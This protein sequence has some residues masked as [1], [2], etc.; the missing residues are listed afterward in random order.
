MV[1]F[2]G[3][4]AYDHAE[5]YRLMFG[6]MLESR[7]PLVFKCSAGKDRTGVAAGLI[8]SLLGVPREHITMVDSLGVIYKGRGDGMNPYKEAFARSTELRTL[9]DAMRGCD[10]FLGCSKAGTV[11]PEMVASMAD[12]PIVFALAGA[13]GWITG[14]RADQSA[15]RRGIG[16]VTADPERRLLK[17]SPLADWTRQAVQDFAAAHEVPTNPL[18][19]KGFPSIGCAPCTR[20]VGPGE[21]ERA[22]RWW[23]EEE[24]KRECGLH[25]AAR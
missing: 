8:L 22:G 20:A 1:R 17:L 14:L 21:S 19:R 6:A 4:L 2:Y 5:S 10:L 13:Q 25:V 12:R 16:C 3:D 7:L 11:T 18:H 9:A 24:S 15:H 23:W